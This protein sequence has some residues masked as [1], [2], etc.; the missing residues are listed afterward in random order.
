[1]GNLFLELQ[2]GGEMYL[3]S[4]RLEP[5]LL[6]HFRELAFYNRPFRKMKVLGGIFELFKDN[7]DFHPWE[8]VIAS[9][10]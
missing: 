3:I 2:A 10:S 9:W 8:M 5:Y 4:S 7:A 1:M 6:L